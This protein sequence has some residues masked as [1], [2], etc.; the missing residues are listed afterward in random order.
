M[1]KMYVDVNIVE[2]YP[3]AGGG[4]E[5]GAVRGE[6]EELVP[7]ARQGPEPPQ[8]GVLGRDVVSAGVHRA[9]DWS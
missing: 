1:H 7:G 2:H 6:V 3:A 5:G 4:A 8:P 9:V